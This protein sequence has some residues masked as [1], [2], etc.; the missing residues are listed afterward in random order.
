VFSGVEFQRLISEWRYRLDRIKVI[1]NPPIWE[2]KDWREFCLLL[3][4]LVQKHGVSWIVDP[5][6]YWDLRWQIR[7]T[8]GE[9]ICQVEQHTDQ[10]LTLIVAQSGGFAESIGT[11]TWLWAEFDA[12]GHFTKDPYWVEGTWKEALMMLILPYHHRAGFY[13]GSQATTPQDFLLQ[14]G[15]R[16]NP[17]AQQLRLE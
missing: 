16:P 5:N 9:L 15:A 7:G 1:L 13:L 3:T 10:H 8:E 14:E 12:E 6:I 17:N 11:Y 4:S 2:E